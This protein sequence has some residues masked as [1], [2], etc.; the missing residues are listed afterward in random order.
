MSDL[1]AMKVHQANLAQQEL[2]VHKAPLVR[3]VLQANL[4]M[5]A[6]LEHLDLLV[7][8][9][10]LEEGAKTALQVLLELLVL[11]EHQ[12]HLETWEHKDLLGLLVPEVLKA[13]EV[14]KVLKD[15]KAQW[16]RLVMLDLLECVVCQEMLVQMAYKGLQ[17]A[18]A[19]KEHWVHKVQWAHLG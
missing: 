9:G 10:Q 19:S 16:G 1:T 6:L 17:E 13:Q 4:E 7:L 12:V 15:P 5:L 2:W 3:K 11:L 8:K 14:H 18:E